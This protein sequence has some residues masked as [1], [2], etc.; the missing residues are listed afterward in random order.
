MAIIE[1]NVTSNGRAVRNDFHKQVRVSFVNFGLNRF[2]VPKISIMIFIGEKVLEEAKIK[3]TDKISM[4]IDTDNTNEF[5][6]KLG[7]EG[8]TLHRVGASYKMLI[9]WK[10]PIPDTFKTTK[11]AKHEIVDRGIK[12]YLD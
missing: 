3:P 4:E 2:N 12:I 9:K 8:Y 11:V 1:M 5:L 10:F 6:I 7:K